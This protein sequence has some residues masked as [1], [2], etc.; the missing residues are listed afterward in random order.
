MLAVALDACPKN[1]D[2]IVLGDSFSGPIALNT[3]VSAE[4]KPISLVLVNTFVSSP[5]NVLTKL[6]RYTP[7]KLLSNPPERVLEYLLKEK[8]A[9][10]RPLERIV[11][12][13]VSISPNLVKSRLMSIDTVSVKNIARRVSVPVC[14]LQAANDS[15]IS[16]NARRELT[17]S[18]KN[19]Q[20]HVLP[21]NHFSLQTFPATCAH[22]I[23]QFVEKHHGVRDNEP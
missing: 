8:E 17:Q 7:Q 15:A 21:G 10:L 18:L 4:H 2:Y 1:E 20:I 16:N 14:V 5:R 9:E 11:P 23:T 13:L 3:A 12:V 22:L 6:A 19:R